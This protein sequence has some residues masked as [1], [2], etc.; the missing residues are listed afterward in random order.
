MAQEALEGHVAVCRDHG[1]PI[2]EPMGLEAAMAH[3]FAEDALVFFVVSLAEPEP[4]AVRLNVS[5]PWELVQAVDRHARAH[6]LSRSAF[7]ARAARKALE[8][9]A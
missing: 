2:P 3:E 4:R 7:L 8:V 5:L 6:G 9:D 1:D